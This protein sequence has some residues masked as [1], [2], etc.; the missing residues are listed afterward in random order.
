MPLLSH[1]FKLYGRD[2]KLRRMTHRHD[3][4]NQWMFKHWDLRNT[5]MCN[6]WKLTTKLCGS[7]SCDANSDAANWKEALRK[8]TATLGVLRANMNITLAVSDTDSEH[9]PTFHVTSESRDTAVIYHMSPR[10]HQNC[11]HSHVE[12]ADRSPG[13]CSVLETM[14]LV[15]GPVLMTSQQA[16]LFEEHRHC[17][18][19]LL[20]YRCK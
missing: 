8:L 4:I 18:Q 11:V 13:P 10:H 6:I 16:Q 17:W 1:S 5:V 3:V 14:Q 2:W 12:C 20:P 19:I 15:R 7:A 9:N